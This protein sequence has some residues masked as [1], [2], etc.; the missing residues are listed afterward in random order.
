VSVSSVVGSGYRAASAALAVLALALCFAGPAPNAYGDPGDVGV[1]DGSH[2]GTSTPT[3][4]KRAESVLWFNDGSWWA[5]M[6]DATSQ[7]FHIFRLDGAAQAWVD[8]GVLVEPRPNTHADVLWDG[9]HLYV[10][11]HAFVND[12]EPAVTGF[13]SYLYR[14]S[15]DRSRRTY[16]LDAGFP[17]QI[18]NV[19]TETLSLERDSTGKLWTTWQQGNRIMVNRTVGDDRTWGAPFALPTA[20]AVTVDDTSALIAFGGRVG[21]MW[22]DQTPANDGMHFS[23]HQ[24]GA[25]DASWSG[26]QA[27]IQGAGSG[28]DH[29]NLKSVE[30]SGGRVYAAVKTSFTASTAPLI[31]LLVLDPAAGVWQSYPIARVSDCPNRVIVLIDDESS[32]VHTYATYPAPPSFGCSSSGG[33]IYEKA[34]PLSAISF[35]PGRGTLRILDADSPFMH[36]V[37]STKQNVNSRTGI[38]VLAADAQTKRYWHSFQPLSPVGPAAPAASFDATPASGPAP[39]AVSFTDTSTGGPASWAWDFGDGSS[40]GTQNASHTYATPGSYTVTLTAANA[41]GRSTATR[42]VTATQAPP[43]GQVTRQSTSTAIATTA[44]SSVT[45]AAPSGTSAGDVLVACLALNGG[46]VAAA[47]APAGWSPL[48]TVTSIAN[49]H[50]LGYYRVASGAEPAQYRWTLASAVSSGA[51]IARYSGA[52]GLD[53]P[54]TMA[55]A[56]SGTSASIPGVTTTVAGAMLVGCAGINSSAT[57]TLIASPAGMSEAWDVGGKRHELADG[58]QAAAGPSGPKTWTLS[59]S[60]AWAGWLVALRPR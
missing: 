47:G 21:L 48:A 18:N 22:S 41:G 46:D 11:S 7:H 49:P 44:A 3:G 4:T 31:M 34:S 56:A 35:P 24:D 2:S 36:N 40:A 26:R 58:V 42:T 50:V 57:S 43:P 37:S 29:M 38:V 60:R 9:T 52:S 39:L 51:G 25:A 53:G 5:D 54:A 27:A 33:A 23:V 12:E 28:D 55:A 32:V 1:Q 45:V 17:T 19:K 8:T 15:Y 10:S 30:A 6:W 16:S 20:S 13:P 59:A 14:F